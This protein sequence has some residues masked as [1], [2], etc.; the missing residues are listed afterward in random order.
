MVVI[1][2]DSQHSNID[3]V[4]NHAGLIEK[5]EDKS[6]IMYGSTR[7][8][9]KHK[10]IFKTSILINLFLYSITNLLSLYNI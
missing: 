5:N 2:H 1:K 4:V 8:N 7:F 3:G 9:G 10:D 6:K